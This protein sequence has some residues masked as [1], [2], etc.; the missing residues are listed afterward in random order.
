VVWYL[1]DNEENS[2]GSAPAEEWRGE[3]AWRDR[4]ASDRIH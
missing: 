2:I 4:S 3:P 1:A